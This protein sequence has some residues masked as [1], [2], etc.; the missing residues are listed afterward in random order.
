MVQLNA[1][2]PR[3]DAHIVRLLDTFHFGQHLCIVLELLDCSLLQYMVRLRL[4]FEQACADSTCFVSAHETE[5]PRA[6]GRNPHHRRASGALHCTS[7]QRRDCAL[8]LL[9]L[10]LPRSLRCCS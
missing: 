10:L 6:G 5:S 1:A 9:L 4:R 3:G 2:D 7:V 8:L